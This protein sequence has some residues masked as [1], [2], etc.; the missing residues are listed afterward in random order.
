MVRWECRP[1]LS[2]LQLQVNDVLDLEMADVLRKYLAS[3]SVPC[4]SLNL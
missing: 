1:E 3:A 2:R 4:G